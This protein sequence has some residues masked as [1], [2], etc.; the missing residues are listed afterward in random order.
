MAKKILVV[1][2]EPDV[3][4]Y[5]TTLL[6]D[7]GYEARSAYDG[8]AAMELIEQEAPD[9]ILLDLMMP[10]E[11]GTGLYR[12]LHHRKEFKNIPVIVI[13]GVA[14][15]DLAVSKSV[16]VFEK[17]IDEAGLLRAIGQSLEGIAETTGR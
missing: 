1:D 15:R 13:S 7:S 6:E 17:P 14:G 4:E 16:P 8:I 11:T 5:L 12:K 2:D 10:E 9:L 3:R